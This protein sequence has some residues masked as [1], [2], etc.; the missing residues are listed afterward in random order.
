MSS[1]NGVEVRVFASRKD[2]AGLDVQD[3]SRV[4]EIIRTQVLPKTEA[5]YYRVDVKI[6]RRK[7]QSPQ[8][9]I[10]YLLRKDIY[11]AEVVRVDVESNFQVTGTT[12]NY[13]SSTEDED[14]D[15]DE[16]PTFSSS[17]EGEYGYAYDFIVATPV[18][19]IPTAKK[20]VEDLHKQF[21]SLGFSSKMLLGT[22]ATIANYKQYL[23]SGL[24]GFINIGH[25]NPNSIAL[26]D[27][28]L[29]ATW[30]ENVANQAVKPAVV[31]FNSCQVHNDPLKSAVI[32]AGART[33]IGG[34]VNLLIGPSEAVCVCFWEN[35]VKSSITM[36]DALRQCEKNKYPAEGAHGIIGDTG[37]FA[38]VSLKIAHA[39]WVH[40]HSMEIEYPERL[41]E[42]ARKGFYVSTRGMPFTSNWFHFAIPT[43]VIVDGNRLLVGSV[44]IRFRTG[45]SASVHAVHIYDGEEKIVAHDS[46]ALSPQGSFIFS[47][48]DV[49]THPAIKWGLGISIGVKFGDGANLPPNKL[50]VEISAAGCDFMLKAS[51]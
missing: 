31:Y 44:M 42:Q 11:L 48:F 40:G 41:S 5:E 29:S 15:E 3:E 50:L 4:A 7:D 45:P 25:G 20:A 30:F 17:D 36:S 23:T 12:W 6:K 9:L 8:Y 33:F 22:E 38:V 28:A 10:A 47:R 14:E 49:P 51:N 13:D 2:Y 16:E 24:K 46:L 19:D 43:P 32:K 35:A 1:Q 21:T 37:L 27:G 26:Y 34:I 18:P 39:M